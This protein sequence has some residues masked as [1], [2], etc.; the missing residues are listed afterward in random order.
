MNVVSIIG[1]K[2][3]KWCREA[4]NLA[5]EVADSVIYKDLDAPANAALREWFR[6]EGLKTVPQVFVD[7]EH[8][9]GFE[10]FAKRVG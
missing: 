2:N 6:V 7:G 5:R 10:E 9:G 8:V 4:R 1:R 3:C